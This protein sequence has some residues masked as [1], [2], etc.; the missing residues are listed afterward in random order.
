MPKGNLSQL[1]IACWSYEVVTK[2][3]KFKEPLD[4]L[5]C[6]IINM[7]MDQ[8][9][10]CADPAGICPVVQLLRLNVNL[11]KMTAYHLAR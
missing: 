6:I 3:G 4:D 2:D 1:S 8:L 7:K 5:D 9:D 10:K 11:I